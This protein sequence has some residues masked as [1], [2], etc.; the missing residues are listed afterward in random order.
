MRQAVFL[1]LRPAV[2]LTICALVL[3]FLGALGTVVALLVSSARVNTLGDN[4]AQL[5]RFV[6]VADAA[7]N[8]AFL[9]IDVLLAS[10]DDLLDLSTS[11]VAWP[12]ADATSAL[13]S[14]IMRQ[15]LLVRSVVL[16]DSQGR[17]LASSDPAG[18]NLRLQLPAGLLERVLAPSMSTLVVSD[19]AVSF[20]SAEQVLY[21]SRYFRMSDGT[22]LV[23][24]AEVTTAALVSILLQG[25]DIQGL[26]VTLERAQ[27]GVLLALASTGEAAVARTPGPLGTTAQISTWE[28]TMRL[29]PVPGFVAVRPILYQDL[30]LTA[31]MPLH[32]ALQDWQPQQ[33]TLWG[34]ALVLGL[35]VV[36]AGVL[37]CLYLQRMVRVRSAIAQSKDT[38]EQALQSMVSGLMLLDAQQRVVQWN[39]HFEALFPWLMPVLVPQMPF[40]RMLEA[41]VLHH[42]PQGSQEEQK[43]WVERRLLEQQGPHGPQ[44]AREQQLPSGRIVQ[45]TERRTPG[46]G[47]VIVYHDVTELRQASAEIEI[48]AFY[49]PLTGLPNRRL[50]LDRLQQAAAVLAR[51]G[52][53]GA[54]LFL[55]LD[56]FKVLNDTKGHDMGDQLLR[57]VAQRLKAA[58]RDTD[59][60]ARLG[61]D[62]F[63][64]MLTDLSPDRE[65]AAAQAQRVGEKVLHNLHEPYNLGAHVHYSSC[66]IGATL[67]GGAEQSATELLRQA[68]IAMYEI[69]AQ[70]GNGLCFFDPQMQTLISQR[71]QLESDLQ[72]ALQEGQLVLY[73]QP[74]FMLDGRMV[75]AEALLR[76]QHPQRGMVSPAEFIPV[77]EESGLIVQIGQWVLHTVCQQLADWSQDARYS[78]LQLSANVSA[79]QF[80]HSEFVPQV[81]V[82]MQEAKIR[83]HLLKL[84]LTESLVLD[85]VKNAIAKMHQLRTRGVQFSV[86]DFGTGYS[87]LAYL[88]SLPLHELKIDQSFVRNLGQRPTDDVIV[89]TIIGMA[90]NLGLEVIAEGVETLEQ[91]EFLAL[92]G[93]RFY[94]GYLFGRPMPV[95]ELQVLLNA[96][97]A[98]LENQNK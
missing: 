66:S 4:E 69:K 71:A 44:A 85:N 91:K 36:L 37:A 25:V 49:D 56:H 15:N 74:Q 2:W 17:V 67:F 43:N 48:L 34:A 94:Q 16:L 86:D 61:G 1:R 40:R 52:H 62:E 26:E 68:D 82:A 89:Q 11:M 87:S 63:V 73:Y 45:I 98:A 77:A 72:V 42:L 31:G 30:W 65:E 58:V 79:R 32:M 23:A 38:L 78:H 50:L 54:V 95:A 12:R 70:R 47:L 80:R 29:S 8:R 41:T 97:H 75:G 3:V 84:E 88:T 93:C 51:S 22:K 7:L 28:Q 83:P 35:M 27:G 46:G 21:F 81:L 57:Q 20:V 14:G 55:D 13:L 76:W 33:R 53:Q 90:S 5:T 39:Q 96:Q 19:P 24:V 59:T 60:V 18:A 92:H 64:V 9:S 10:T 6:S